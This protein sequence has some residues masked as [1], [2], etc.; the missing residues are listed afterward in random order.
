MEY[1]LPSA[2]NKI[3][4]VAYNHLIDMTDSDENDDRIVLLW[5]DPFIESPVHN[6]QQVMQQLRRTNDYV[7][8]LTD[9]DQCTEFIRGS[10]K[11]KIFFITSGSKT[12][13]ILMPV[14]P[15]LTQIHSVFI[16]SMTNDFPINENPKII[17]IFNN[18][19]E[20]CQTIREQIEFHDQQ[21]QTFSF[22]NQNQNP[23]KDLSKESA[24]FLWFQLFPRVNTLLLIKKQET[25]PM[26]KR[27][28]RTNIRQLQLL[29][30][31]DS[32]YK[33]EDAIRWYSK[34]STIYRLV[35]KSFRKK[36]ID[37]LETFRFFIYDL[38]QRL[39]HE[40]DKILSSRQELLTVYRGMKLDKKKFDKIKENQGKL[41]SMNGYLLTTRLPQL[42]FDV[43]RKPTKQGGMN[44]VV[45]RI[46]CDIKQLDKNVIFAD[47]ARLSEYPEKEE[48]LFDLNTCFRIISIEEHDSIQVIRM[49]ASS[50]GQR[51][52]NDYVDSTQDEIRQKSLLI[53]FGKLL[54][55]IGEYDQAQKYFEKL[56]DHI[57]EHKQPKKYGKELLKNQKNEDAPWIQ[58]HIGRALT[59]KKKWKEA[60]EYYD[61]AYNQM[62]NKSTEIEYCGYVLSCIGSILRQ[63]GDNDEAIYY[64]EQAVKMREQY[65]P[66]SYGDIAVDLESIAAILTN[67]VKYNAA[68]QY[69]R[70]ALKQREKSN[71]IDDAKI[72]ENLTS[73]GKVLYLVD[74]YEE[75]LNHHRGALELRERSFPAGHIDIARS[76]NNVGNILDEQ[77]YFEQALGF[78]QRALEIKR[79]CYPR[80]HVDIG[81]SLN[82]MG[83]CYQNQNKLQ[84]ALDYYRQA[85]DI[86]AQ[87]LPVNDSHRSRVIRNIYRLTG[88]N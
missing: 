15:P 71:P 47:I 39:N 57:T 63:Q 12:S 26:S 45:F 35:N 4:S 79:Q 68:L 87:F 49:N 20:L 23:V 84:I 17:G 30:E 34:Q 28:Y 74:K 36:D 83:A 48:V 2:T 58:F 21:L 14:T 65:D 32:E 40:H 16:F 55:D 13:K 9:R 50:E 61:R 51:I 3:P 46:E 18:S 72:A 25:D 1:K 7:K 88:N 43:A 53:V 27:Y 62:K 42:A 29:K 41:I 38:S 80:G 70:E 60:K 24:E 33:A 6:S 85:R 69:Y 78:H 82:N 81:H 31:F 19:D 76:L 44:S 10:N 67:Q 5:Y 86:Y 22:F 75:A 56:L 52:I 77:G 11:E 37:Q 66:V 54:C 64:F 73:A 8:I 59:F